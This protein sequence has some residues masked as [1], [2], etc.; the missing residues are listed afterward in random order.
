[1][2]LVRNQRHMVFPYHLVPVAATLMLDNVAEPRNKME[3][4]ACPTFLSSALVIWS[5]DVHSVFEDKSMA[6]DENRKENHMCFSLHLV[7]N[8][9]LGTYY[10]SFKRD[11]TCS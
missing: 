10:I 2:L 7:L 3:M 6:S 4:R 9:L 5:M 8:F 1:M 11:L